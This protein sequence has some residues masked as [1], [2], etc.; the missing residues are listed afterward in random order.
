MGNLQLE[1][2]L[3]QMGFAKAKTNSAESIARTLRQ[4]CNGAFGSM[5]VIEREKRG[6][7]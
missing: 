1:Q 7:Y 2:R 4:S 5:D 6:Q 3:R